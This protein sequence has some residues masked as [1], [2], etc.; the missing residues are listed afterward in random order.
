MN[1]AS[2]E[3]DNLDNRTVYNELRDF[4]RERKEKSLVFTNHHGHSY[5]AN[6]VVSTDSECVIVANQAG[7]DTG[8]I[9]KTSNLDSNMFPAPWSA[10][11]SNQMRLHWRSSAA[12]TIFMMLSRGSRGGAWMTKLSNSWN[13]CESVSTR[14]MEH[15]KDNS[16]PL[17]FMRFFESFWRISTRS[18]FRAPTRMFAFVK[19]LFT[20]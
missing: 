15:D 6:M 5:N 20:R 4:I 12:L 1:P 3:L 17:K 11:F 19:K 8:M 7:H 13:R 10:R 9:W 18:R 14:A 2:G 16:S